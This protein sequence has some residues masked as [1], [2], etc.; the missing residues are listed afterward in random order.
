[1]AESRAPPEAELVRPE[2]RASVK[3]ELETT[4]FY[5]SLLRPLVVGGEITPRVQD[6]GH[7]DGADRWLLD[8]IRK[9]GSW[10]NRT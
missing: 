4:T 8:L 10:K 3:L 2:V 9:G 5:L 7:R 6:W 1:M